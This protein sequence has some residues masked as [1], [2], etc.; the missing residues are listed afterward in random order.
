MRNTFFS[1]CLAA[2]AALS[3]GVPAK[4]TTQ[5][6]DVEI[7]FAFSV[8]KTQMPAGH[9]RIQRGVTN[10]TLILVNRETGARAQVMKPLGMRERVKELVFREDKEGNY[11]LASV[12]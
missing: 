5:S 10:N 7:R 1:V 2:A 12:R 9:Y 3:G 11:V 8:N 6:K 4:A